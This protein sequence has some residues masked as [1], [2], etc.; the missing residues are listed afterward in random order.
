MFFNEVLGESYDT[1]SK[2]LTLSELQAASTLP[3]KNDPAAPAEDVF[4]RLRGYRATALGIDWGGG[5]AEQVSFTTLA[6]CG[7]RHDGTIDVV[8]G[9]R[10][11]TPND[12]AREA[13]QCYQ[14]I[15]KFRPNHIA[16]DFNGAGA[17]RETLLVQAGVRLGAIIPIHYAAVRAKS[18]MEYVSAAD[19]P[20]S[21]RPYYSVDRTR[22]LLTVVNSI[23]F[24]KVRFFEHDFISKESPGLLRD[25]TSLTEEKIETRTADSY[26]I[27]R[28][29]GQ[30]DDFAHAVTYGCC[31]LWH[32]THGWPDLIKSV[33]LGPGSLTSGDWLS[34][35]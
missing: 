22:V 19:D 17:L 34:G 26:V 14:V 6:L 31:A 18:I 8:W 20:W 24:G 7:L 5:G 10:L 12:H 2:L 15:E 28:M 13:A 25:F 35:R 32:S 23:K 4:A 1:G 11:M 27:R 29:P 33:R 16:H 30:P 21:K 3:W 9:R